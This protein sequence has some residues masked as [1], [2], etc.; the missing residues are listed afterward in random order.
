MR[1]DGGLLAVADRQVLELEL[2][3]GRAVGD[4]DLGLFGSVHA[5]HATGAPDSGSV[6][7]SRS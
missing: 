6:V 7:R 4:G 2:V 3:G 5:R 1:P